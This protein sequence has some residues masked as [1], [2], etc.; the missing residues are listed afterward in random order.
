MPGIG[1]VTGPD[2]L[3]SL[4]P[5]D[6]LD[7]DGVV[8]GV[9]STIV[10][11]PLFHAHA[12]INTSFLLMCGLTQVLSGRF[13]PARVLKEIEQHRVSYITGT[14]AMWHALVTH[15]DV[16]SR[17]LSSVRV[18]SSGAAPIDPGTLD[19]LRRAFTGAR[20]VEGYGLTEATCLVT[21]APL[22]ADSECPVGSV[23]LPVFDTEI[24]DSR[25]RRPGDSPR[26][27]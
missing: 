24:R 22:V 21:A 8:P 12:L 27:G 16:S 7:I 19:S 14:P 26:G 11:S 10:V 9:G 18:V 20:V 15:P 2:G 5:I 6:G 4:E 1:L 23:G 17:D 3:V 13:D 25:T